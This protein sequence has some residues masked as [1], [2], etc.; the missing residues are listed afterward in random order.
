MQGDVWGS[1]TALWK[2]ELGGAGGPPCRA[3]DEVK[4]QRET[5]SLVMSFKHLG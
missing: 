4:T 3:E 1:G 2:G 5:E